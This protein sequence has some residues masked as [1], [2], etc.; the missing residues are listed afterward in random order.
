MPINFI[1]IQNTE[2][3]LSTDHLDDLEIRATGEN[4]FHYFYNRKTRNLITDFILKNTKL[5]KKICK[6]TLIRVPE[7][8]KFAPR[9]EV[10]IWSN[11]KRAIAELDTPVE[12]AE[13]RLIKARVNLDDCHDNFWKLINYL[14]G[15]KDI[16]LPEEVR[17]FSSTDKITLLNK[18][19]VDP[20]RQEILESLRPEELRNLEQSVGLAK[21]DKTLGFWDQNKN[22]RQEEIWH[23]FFRENPWILSQLFASPVVIF[24]DKAYA[25][26]KGIDNTGGKIADFIY[27]NELSQNIAIIEIKTPMTKLISKDKYRESIYPV[28]ADVIG[29]MTQLLSQKGDLLKNYYSLARNSKEKFETINPKCIL[30]IG[31]LAE[32]TSNE[33]IDYLTSFEHYRNNI[34]SSL[35]II[36]FDEVFKKLELLD[37][38][39]RI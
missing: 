2:F 25:G 5:S 20:K 32:L 3:N 13:I 15:V 35:T 33:N 29:G 34:D 27:K 7:N 38:I 11:T 26:G 22:N 6:V 17:S 10:S 12:S 36:T 37:S 4:G 21:L 18:F 23:Q 24:E 9:L 14:R 31:T 28:H 30:V 19:I 39:L 8:N 1:R 16:D